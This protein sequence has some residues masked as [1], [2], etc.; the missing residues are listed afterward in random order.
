MVLRN[1]D[2]AS[3]II[4]VFLLLRSCPV[5]DVTQV[6][7]VLPRP[8][9]LPPCGCGR[10]GHLE[11]R[12]STSRE[13]GDHV[14]ERPGVRQPPGKGPGED[15]P[16]GWERLDQM[17][18]SSACGLHQRAALGPS[19]APAQHGHPQ[20]HWRPRALGCPSGRI[21]LPSRLRAGV[22]AL[23]KR[24][25]FR[26]ERQLQEAP[27][28]DGSGSQPPAVGHDRHLRTDMRRFPPGY[29]YITMVCCF[30]CHESFLFLFL[31]HVR[32]RSS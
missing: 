28:A 17:A 13:D 10:H 24:L 19:S 21:P 6:W 12:G 5:G 14:R 27:A 1:L 4:T 7:P 20:P 30:L 26:Q 16:E 29:V 2:P 11:P 9:D 22:L 8:F 23:W 3:R 18:R 15:S 31:S 25:C 32:T